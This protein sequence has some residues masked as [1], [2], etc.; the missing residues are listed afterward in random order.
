MRNE[1]GSREIKFVFALLLLPLSIAASTTLAQSGNDKAGVSIV[2]PRL[3]DLR[4]K[5]SESLF[6]LDYEG[7]RQSFKEMARLFPDDPTGPQ[8]LA[9]TIWLETLNKSRLLQASIYSTQSFYAKTEE[10]PDP[11]ISRDFHDLARQA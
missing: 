8:M 6:N 11:Q 3:E 10:K 1:I 5:G 2:A 7:A 4:R 9:S